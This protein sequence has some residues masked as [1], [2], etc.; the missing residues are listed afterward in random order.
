MDINGEAIDTIIYNSDGKKIPFSWGN[1]LNL[2]KRNRKDNNNN[3]NNLFP[4]V[5]VIM[6]IF[7][8]TLCSCYFVTA[9]AVLICTKG[10][11][12]LEPHVRPANR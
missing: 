4:S 3:N 1:C 10:G 12:G 7:R 6:G 2:G 5:H 9:N 8:T 11:Y